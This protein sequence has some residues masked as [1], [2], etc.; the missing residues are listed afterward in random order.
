MKESPVKHCSCLKSEPMLDLFSPLNSTQAVNFWLFFFFLFCDQV[1]FTT[2]T[3][4]IIALK[5][6]FTAFI[7]EC[8]IVPLQ[9]G[10]LKVLMHYLERHHP[11]PLCTAE[12]RLQIHI[13]QPT[14]KQGKLPH[15]ISFFRS[16]WL[17]LT[18]SSVTRAFPVSTTNPEALCFCCLHL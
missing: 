3:E 16:D 7:S 18:C 11:A 1:V 13:W 14:S 12:G 2:N 10:Y 8:E 9:V 15:L 17:V 4:L 6:N 5:S